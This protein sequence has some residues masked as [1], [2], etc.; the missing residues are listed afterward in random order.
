MFLSSKEKLTQICVEQQPFNPLGCTESLEKAETTS[1]VSFSPAMFTNI[2]K[3]VEFF[4]LKD[5]LGQFGALTSVWR[6]ETW[7]CAPRRCRF[8]SI[9]TGNPGRG[10]RLGRNP[11]RLGAYRCNLLTTEA[12][13]EKNHLFLILLQ[14]LRTTEIF[15]SAPKDASMQRE[16]HHMCI[17]IRECNTLI[18]TPAPHPCGECQACQPH[19]WQGSQCGAPPEELA[20]HMPGFFHSRRGNFYIPEQGG[21]EALWVPR[22]TWSEY[23]NTS[24]CSLHIRGPVAIP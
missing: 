20:T 9:L 22:K 23:E 13:R 15:P 7:T 17:F 16:K 2:F 3:W 1:R 21:Q 6:R 10:L 18:A 4:R 8:V 12:M 19:L 24:V 11:C 5:T 14:S